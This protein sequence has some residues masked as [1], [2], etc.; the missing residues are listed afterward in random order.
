VGACGYVLSCHAL[1]G[2][3]L[4]GPGCSGAYP[5]LESPGCDRSSRPVEIMGPILDTVAISRAV[6]GML[7]DESERA[8]KRIQHPLL[9]LARVRCL[10]ASTVTPRAMRTNGCPC[11]PICPLARSGVAFPSSSSRLEKERGKKAKMK[12]KT[13]D[14]IFLADLYFTRWGKSYR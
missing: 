3:A 6:E 14:R 4:N 7:F 5:A 2:V 9:H 11:A 10:A 12:G 8:C 13:R 1:N